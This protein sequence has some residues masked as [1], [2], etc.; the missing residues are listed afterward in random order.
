M[1]TAEM[2]KNTDRVMEK[3]RKEQAH[4]WVFHGLST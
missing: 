1:K 2:N 3:E 4:I